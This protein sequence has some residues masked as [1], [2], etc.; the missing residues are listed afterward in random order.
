MSDIRA[1]RDKANDHRKHINQNNGKHHPFRVKTAPAD[2]T[3][4]GWLPK[5]KLGGMTGKRRPKP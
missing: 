4:R 3:L 1:K 5:G 2:P